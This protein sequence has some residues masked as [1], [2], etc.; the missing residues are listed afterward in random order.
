MIRAS[1]T[2][3][4]VRCFTLRAEFG[5]H[6]LPS[7]KAS[8][9]VSKFTPF[10]LYTVASLTGGYVS[11]QSAASGYTRKFVHADSPLG[12]RL[13][14][15]AEQHN[16]SWITPFRYPNQLPRRAGVE[17]THDLPRSQSTEPRASAP[18]YPAVERHDGG[19]PESSASRHRPSER[20]E[21]EDT[22]H[23]ADRDEEEQ[24]E[25][26]GA[27]V[28]RTMTGSRSQDPRRSWPRNTT[29]EE[30]EAAA[31][32]NERWS[33]NPRTTSSRRRRTAEEEERTR[34]HV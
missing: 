29:E 3:A 1:K 20:R 31:Q 7:L 4:K 27:S 30:L 15:V 16:P 24:Q 9:V 6:E 19:E 13:R 2:N 17:D 25:D 32:E 18:R 28:P 21:R 22:N 11:L 34:R 23:D 33:D 8:V 10:V 26:R 5:P 14:Q 12:E